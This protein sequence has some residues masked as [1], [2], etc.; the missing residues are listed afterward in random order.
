M[1]DLHTHSNFSDGACH[2]E[3]LLQKA[4]DAKLECFALTDHDTLSGLPALHESV[5]KLASKIK[6]INGVELSVRWKKHELHLIGLNVPLHSPEFNALI[7]KQAESRQKRALEIGNRLSDIGLQYAYQKAKSIAG[8]A[9]VARPHFAQVLLEEGFVKTMQGA[10]DRYLKRGRKA[11]VPT[12]WLLM[13]EAIDGIKSCGG[14]SVLAHPCKYSLTRTKLN[15]LIVQFKDA[16][17]DAVEVVSGDTT[18]AQVAEM[19]ALCQKFGLKASTGSDFH[20]DKAAKV[21][22]GMQRTLP[23]NCVPIW[24]EWII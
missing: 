15:E 8:H 1:I 24:H 5:N 11:Y 12:Q 6:I 19:A 7:Q 23:E 13:E 3:E 21:G 18:S 20:S 9:E 16:K 2:P 14:L 22:L 17:G 4:I 10:F